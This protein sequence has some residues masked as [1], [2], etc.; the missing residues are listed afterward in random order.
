MM[1]QTAPDT[2]PGGSPFSLKGIV[3]GVVFSV[4]VSLAAPYV[5]FMLQ[6][7]SVGIN[8]SSPAAIFFFFVLTLFVNVLLGLIRRQFALGRA[9]LI[10]VY[11]MLLM[12]VTAPTYNFLNYLISMV[13][14]PFYLASTENNFAVVLL[15]HIPEWMVPQDEE[16]IFALYEGLPRGRSIPWGAWVEPLAHWFAFFIG[17]SFMMICMA[18]ILHRQWSRHERL[19]YPM[20][21]LPLQMIE[22]TRPSRV[23]AFFKNKV[24]WLGFSVP[25][26][27]FSL[28]GLNHYVSS[29]PEFP[30]YIAWIHWFR[31]TGTWGEGLALSYAWLGFFYLV[32]LNISFSIWFFFLIGKLQDGLFRTLG[33]HSTEQLSQYEYSQLADLTHQAVGATLV[34]VLLGLWTARRH[35][36]NVVVKAWRPAAGVNDSEELMSYR[37]AVFGLIGSG[38]FVCFWLWR[39]GLPLIVIPAFLFICAVY[40]ILITRV[41]AA[42]G[43]PTAR[44]PLV[45]PF[46]IVSGM[47][48]SMLGLK[49]TVALCFT[50]VWQAEMRLFPMLACA[51]ALKLAES[52]RGSKR[53]LLVA[54][55]LALGCSL[56]GGTA[57]NLH[58]GYTYG[59]INLGTYAG[60]GGNWDLWLPL[61]HDPR[62][63]DLRGWVFTGIGAVFE[64]GL[65]LAQKRWYWWPF[66]PLGFPLAIGWLTSEIWFAAMLAWVLKLLAV[67]YGGPK[68]YAAL[69]PFFLGLI[70]GEVTVAAF[71]ALVDTVMGE[72]GNIITYM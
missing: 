42:G 29:V 58:L 10:L 49:G 53:R 12:A 13:T 22:G 35:L 64:G 28:T 55:L 34:F 7:S 41:V 32:D 66:H 37:L 19:S 70:L 67:R 61:M 72:S 15:P 62:V 63:V 54:L 60:F 52:I 8:S 47:G 24:M 20:A 36:R 17:L 69:K 59:G 26:T 23:P 4:L 31:D 25:F 21:Q 45:A 14:G 43:V 39:S 9:D 46:F 16:A 33:I 44:P 50:M 65:M 56:L 48:T 51:N 27:L 6:A 5:V 40:Y 2:A 3:V 30:F 11:A 57:M 1:Q 18:T 68:L 71:W 38:L